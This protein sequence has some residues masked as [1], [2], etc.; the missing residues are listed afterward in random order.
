MRDV[1]LKIEQKGKV[2]GNVPFDRSANDATIP[3]Q[4]RLDN[5]DQFPDENRGIV[6]GRG[7]ERATMQ[8]FRTDLHRWNA[9]YQHMHRVQGHILLVGKFFRESTQEYR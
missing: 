3:R 1:S 9:I 7:S 4:R 6:V 5:L 2:K 8:R